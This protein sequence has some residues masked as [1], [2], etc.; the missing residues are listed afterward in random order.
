MTSVLILYEYFWLTERKYARKKDLYFS[1][2]N[3]FFL[4]AEGIRKKKKTG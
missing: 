2:K 1:Y 4:H 3:A